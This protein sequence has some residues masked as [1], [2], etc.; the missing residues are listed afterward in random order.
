MNNDCYETIWPLPNILFYGGES[1]RFEITPYN[2]DGERLTPEYAALCSTKLTVSPFSVRSGLGNNDTPVTP[3]I[4][5]DGAVELD[6]DNNPI[7]VFSLTA[8][9]TKTLWGMFVYQIDI[10]NG[11]SAS[12]IYQGKMHIL[13]NID[14]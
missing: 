13:M 12:R 9:D 7:F 10:S 11:E 3:V 14:Q 5:K 6:D 8:S 1:D 4:E 2:Q